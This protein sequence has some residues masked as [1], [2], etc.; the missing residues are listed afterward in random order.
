MIEEIFV[1]IADGVALAIEGLVVLTIA[2]GALEAVGGAVRVAVGGR[3][4][5]RGR[6]ALLHDARREVWFRFA[7]WI[8]LALELA[9]GADIIRT[10]IAPSWES[11]GELGA[12]A[13][14]RTALN[15]F[16]MRDLGEFNAR[17]DEARPKAE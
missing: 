17:A 12:I 14:I 7:T 4:A 8:I 5:E 6:G 11:I 10:A 13:A 2:W 1:T 3:Q 16:L 9:L 15:F